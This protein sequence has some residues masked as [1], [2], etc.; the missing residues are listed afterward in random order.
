MQDTILWARKVLETTPARWI[1]LTDAVP[2]ELLRRPPAPN[3]WSALECLMHIVDTERMVFPARV[4]HFL[5]GEDFPGFDPDSQGS[6]PAVD[7]APADLAAEFRR[8]RAESL[9]LLS[10]IG[11]ADL[12]RTARHQ[13]LGIVTL[14]Q[15]IHAWAGHDLMHTVQAERA[16]LQPFIAECG[17]WQ[18]YFSDHY[19]QPGM[20]RP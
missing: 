7:L 19:V 17:P 3:E 8:L 11:P 14:R 20:K 10:T 15:M 18:S 12:V 4:G 1:S 16:L 13:E 6:K 5:R 2:A 9:A